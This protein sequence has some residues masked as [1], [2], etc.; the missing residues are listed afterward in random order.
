[1]PE[2]LSLYILTALLEGLCLVSL[3]V[4]DSLA[5]GFCII[6]KSSRQLCGNNASHQVPELPS[7]KKSSAEKVNYETEYFTDVRK[8]S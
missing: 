2:I 4:V 5:A 3:S 6:R 1:M 8:L 7:P